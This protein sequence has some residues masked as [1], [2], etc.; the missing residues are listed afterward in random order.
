VGQWG[1]GDDAVG[2]AVASRVRELAPH[3]EVISPADPTALIALLETGERVIVIDAVVSPDA[4]GRVRVLH[5]EEL[6]G[7]VRPVSSHGIGVS[8]AIATA[9]AIL[10]DAA[11][12]EVIVVGIVVEPL[13]AASSGLSVRALA[14]VEEA[15][16]VVVGLG[17]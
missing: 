11:S 13:A 14:A 5:V 16:R 10:G 7:A 3:L 9:R 6:G 17:G 15:A 1:A 2:L 8:D 12:P 4:P